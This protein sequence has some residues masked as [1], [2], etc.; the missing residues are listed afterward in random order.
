MRSSWKLK[1]S[2]VEI[3]GLIGQYGSDTPVAY[4]AQA[5]QAH[6]PS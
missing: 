2:D 4:A 3:D 5:R 1:E 6:N